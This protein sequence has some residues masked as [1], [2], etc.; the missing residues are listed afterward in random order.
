MRIPAAAYKPKPTIVTPTTFPMAT[1]GW[2]ANTNL[3]APPES[4][5]GAVILE[6]IMPTATGGMVRRGSNLYATA[7]DETIPIDSVFSYVTG[8]VKK[9]FMANAHKIYDVTVVAQAENINLVDDLGNAIV[10]DLGNQLGQNSLT[11]LDVVTGLTAGDWIDVQFQTTGGIFLVIVNGDDEMRI[12]DGT[13]WYPIGLKPIVQVNFDTQTTN[14]TIGATIVGGT[15]GATGTLIR[16]T[17]AGATGTLWIQLTSG[18]YVDNETITGGGGS[19]LVNGAQTTFYAAL[20]GIDSRN[21]S[22][23][24]S[25]K[26]RLW[27]IEK[28]TMNVWYL[29][30]DQITGA[31]TKLPMGGVFD[32][33]GTL[34]FGQSWSLGYG[35]SGGLSDQNVFITDEGQA[36]IFQGSNPADPTDWKLVG[37]YRLGKPQGPNAWIRA[38]GDLII[39]TSVGFVPLSEAVQRDIAALS[40][41]AVSY[42]IETAWNDAV[43]KRSGAFWNCITWPE[44]QMVCVALPTVN[45]TTPP[46]MYIT[47]AR[48]G[49]WANFTGW[50]ATCME[51][52]QGRLFFGSQ[53]GKLVEAYVTGADQGTPYTATYVP[54]FTDLGSPM[55]LKIPHNARLRC[56]GP[57]NVD[58]QISVQSDYILNIPTVPSASQVLA[59]S[60][61]GVGLWGQAIWGAG[62]TL[63]IQQTWQSVGG[64]GYALTPCAQITS[65]AIIP[66][67]TELIDLQMTFDVGDIFS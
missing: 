14:F 32:L 2:M 8:A 39:A 44:R 18:T 55:S 29:P 56:R 33:G 6:N 42:P 61:W 52:F 51:V 35:S 20:T 36:A 13:A 7:E 15:S 19:A 53:A 23:V 38:G 41:S 1:G 60:Q 65:G 22:Y 34:M 28:G 59:G 45:S 11:G 63:K 40:P 62:T 16:Q 25:Y 24:W 48:T 37:V 50:S 54:L 47:N 12:Y 3:A 10:D 4:P 17:D 64:T 26:Q 46:S 21:L 5:P 31:L 67:D 30:V 57:Y 43:E 49:A 9:L 66:L 27:F 58:V